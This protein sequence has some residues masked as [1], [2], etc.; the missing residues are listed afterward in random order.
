MSSSILGA[1]DN[2]D[3]HPESSPLESWLVG[4]FERQ[5]LQGRFGSTG[6]GHGRKCLCVFV[7]FDLV[8]L[9][10]E[11]VAS[12]VSANSGFLDTLGTLLC[13]T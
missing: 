11:E 6:V 2:D 12:V 10:M 4:R 9:S 8:V 1:G 5:S 7:S 13:P 3:G